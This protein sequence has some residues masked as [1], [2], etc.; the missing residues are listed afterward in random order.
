MNQKSL[1]Y[2]VW[3]NECKT[4]AVLSRFCFFSA[5]SVRTSALR[6]TTTTR[7]SAHCATP[8]APRTSRTRPASTRTPRT[9][10]CGSSRRRSRTS[11]RS[12]RKVSPGTPPPL[13]WI[14]SPQLFL[15]D[16]RLPQPRLSGPVRSDPQRP[17][18]GGPPRPGV[19]GHA[20]AGA[21]R[22]A[23]GGEHVA[24]SPPLPR[25]PSLG[26]PQDADVRRGIGGFL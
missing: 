21:P 20:A 15:L 7:P 17:A 14:L 19:S 2:F 25:G 26:S 3:E 10:C 9:H 13:T 16:P 4:P 22:L 24:P 8:T 1:Q 12:W 23:C 11:R 6:T 5:A 18:A